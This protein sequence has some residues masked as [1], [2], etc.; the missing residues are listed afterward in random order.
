MIVIATYNCILKAGFKGTD[1]Q[2]TN[3]INIDIIIRI[4][5]DQTVY[6]GYICKDIIVQI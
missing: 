3:V 5:I 6:T 4:T 2:I 1:V